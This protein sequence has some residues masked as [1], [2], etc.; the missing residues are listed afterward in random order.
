MIDRHA[1]DKLA[2]AL[3][4]Y[5]AK[6]ITN[7]ELEDAVA[8]IS[9]DQGVTVVQDMAW[10]LYDDTFRHHADGPHALAKDDR[11]SVARWVLFLQTDLEY[12]W[13]NHDFRQSETSLDRFVAD[14]FTAGR[15][16]RKELRNWEK[17][18]EAGDIE[19]WPFQNIADEEAARR[20]K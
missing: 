7:D 19:V 9:E 16:S 6:R 12:S 1:R 10:R 8:W 20:R 4:R 14:L 18:V 2:L 11:R 17:F 15:W 3:R 13:P 5:A